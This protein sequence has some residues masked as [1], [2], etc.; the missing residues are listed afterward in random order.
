M[1]TGMRMMGK[2]DAEDGLL[3]F[4]AD[5]MGSFM[6]NGGWGNWSYLTL[7]KV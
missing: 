5:G 2:M 1:T 3:M 4:M 7:P 6:S